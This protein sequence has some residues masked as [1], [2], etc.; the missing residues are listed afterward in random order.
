MTITNLT[1]GTDTDGNSTAT[2]ASI[3]PSSNK[4]L[5]LSVASRTG[6]T[7]DPNQPTITG[8]GLT[9]VAIG[10]T[11]YDNTSS[12]RRRITLFRALGAS[13]SSGAIS[14]DFG[15]QNQTAVC[16]SVE[17]ISGS[18]TSGTNGSGAITQS[19]VNQDTSGT[20]SSL[21][22]TLSSFSSGNNATYGCFGNAQ[23]GVWNAGS[24][25]TVL[26]NNQVADASLALISEYKLTNDT[27]VDA[28][29]ASGSGELGGIAIEIAAFSLSSWQ[30]PTNSPVNDTLGIVPY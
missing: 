14:I 4:P 6:I 26:S 9:W 22:V 15:G 8:N 24:G 18:D 13:P 19:A 23:T 1:S 21:T 10:T 30:Q 16:W 29:L 11:V 5:L 12:S 25:F 17:E 2:T 7:A 27:T 20:A 28:S 3:S